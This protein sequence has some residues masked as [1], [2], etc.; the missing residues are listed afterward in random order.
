M[1]IIHVIIPVHTW[2]IPVHTG[3]YHFLHYVPVCTRYRPVHTCTYMY[4]PKTL[5]LYHQSRFQMTGID[6]EDGPQRSNFWRLKFQLKLTWLPFAIGAIFKTPQSH[7]KMCAGM[8]HFARRPAAVYLANSVNSV[9]LVLLDLLVLS[10]LAPLGTWSE[11]IHFFKWLF[12]AVS[13]VS[14]RESGLELEES[15]LMLKNA[16][17]LCFGISSAFVGNN[18]SLQIHSF[19]EDRGKC[20]KMGNPSISD[21]STGP[22]SWQVTS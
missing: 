4:V 22:P 10:L 18:P 2:Y 20:N 9:N 6:A 11:R 12:T 16:W 19:S 3:M 1:A 15:H 8:P 7:C 13:M 5:I 21:F 17:P 14:G